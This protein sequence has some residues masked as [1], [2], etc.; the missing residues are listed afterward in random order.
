M[1]KNLSIL[2]VFKNDTSF[3]ST[4]LKFLNQFSKLISIVNWFIK[5]EKD[6]EPLERQAL[7][8]TLYRFAVNTREISK[9]CG[10]LFLFN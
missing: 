2:S 6:P 1:L 10:R 5:P 8:I 3:Y 7:S 4:G 9:N